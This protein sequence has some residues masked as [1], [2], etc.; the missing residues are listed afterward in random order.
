MCHSILHDLALLSSGHCPRQP[1]STKIKHFLQYPESTMTES[2]IGV[3]NFPGNQCSKHVCHLTSHPGLSTWVLDT[4]ECVQP[5]RWVGTQQLLNLILIFFL[6][7]VS[8]FF[9]HSFS[10][11]LSIFL[12][13][14]ICLSLVKYLFNHL[15]AHLK[16]EFAF[17]LNCTFSWN[18]LI[19]SLLWDFCSQIFFLSLSQC[20]LSSKR[21]IFSY[22]KAFCFITNVYDFVL[23]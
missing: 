20:L 5:F 16:I 18:I 7:A 22:N 19:I 23:H 4:A 3:V 8:I 11:F 17:A 14:A 12:F 21:G 6:I 10:F 1:F 9:M 13:F 15:V 2:S